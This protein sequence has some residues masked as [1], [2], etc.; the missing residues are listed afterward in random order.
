MFAAFFLNAQSSFNQ[1]RVDSLEYIGNL[2]FSNSLKSR[3]EK[4]LNTFSLNTNLHL[5]KKFEDLAIRINE[6]LGSTFIR[7]ELGNTRDEQQLYLFTK[8]ILSQNVNIGLSGNSALLSD[9][10]SLGINE[11]AV[12]YAAFYSEIKP[13]KQLSIA[14]FAGYSNNRQIGRSD[15]GLLYGLEASLFRFG[16]SELDIT[17]E[18]RFRNEDILP[19]RNLIRYYTLS[20][21]NKFDKGFN[22]N[23]RTNFSQNRKD[24]YIDADSSISSTFNVTNNIQSRMETNF[25]LFDRLSYDGFLEI[26]S[27]DLAGGVNWK[28]I[29]REF[30]YKNT[31]AATKNIYDTKIDELKL[32]LDAIAYYNSKLFNGSIRINFYERDE[33]HQVKQF[34]EMPE[35]VFEE[36]S[37]I[38]VQK[39]NNSSRFTVSL[40]GDF[41][42]SKNDGLTFSLHQSKLIYDTKSELNDDD[43]DELLSIARLR[44]TKRLNPYFSAFVNLEG[45]YGHTV[46]LFAS[47]SSNNN[48]N[49][50]FRLR[51]GGDYFGSGLK[52]FNSIEVSANYTV[53]DF[54]D[55]VINYKSYAF[56]QLLAID[57]TTIKINNN[58][59]LFSYGYIKIS[60]IGDFDW[61]DFSSRPTR[62]LEE[63]YF[64]PRA[65]LDLDQKFFSVGLRLFALKTFSF[66]Q[67]S[68]I[69]DTEYLSL[70]PIAI[71]DI[72][73]WNKFN[74]ILK[75]Y[76]EFISN[77]NSVD[78]EQ[79]SLLMQVN[80]NF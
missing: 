38:E 63:I 26:F 39:N 36:K 65:I 61:A 25:Q 22:N 7:N 72:S 16:I 77:T 23:I 10:R 50:I 20:V 15:N 47:R 32:E 28:S 75:G 29:D 4:Q 27:L 60:E 55:V 30:K 43:R 46:Y 13:I 74:L 5:T 14:P 31:Q 51:T 69:L 34:D 66:K 68:K 42:L 62:Y 11:S 17:S 49:R 53:Y 54:K 33:K 73:A 80:W 52:S 41:Y 79:A 2:Y 35:N 58:V 78:K 9:N 19:R 12:N 45:T 70:G 71:I 48:V 44:Y 3:F 59:S 56:R 8:L 21:S 64:E 6:N 67:N 76:Y 37:D 1:T 24:F 40:N 57:S 18:L